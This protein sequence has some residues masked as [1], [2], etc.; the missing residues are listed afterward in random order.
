L[1][2]D[3]FNFQTECA[4]NDC[5]VFDGGNKSSIFKIL[6]MPANS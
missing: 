1:E 5:T 3:S 6:D 4:R 2:S